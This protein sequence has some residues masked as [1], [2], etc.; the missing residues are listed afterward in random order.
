MLSS[1]HQNLKTYQDA[2]SEN[3]NSIGVRRV[4]ASLVDFDRW[5]D[6]PPRSAHEDQLKLHALLSRMS[7]YHMLPLISYNPWS[8][9][10]E[11]GK[12]LALVEDAVRNYGAVGVKIYPPNG[13]LPWAN[14]ATKIPK[15]PDGAEID[16][17]LQKFW[18]TCQDLQVPVL[19]HAGPSMGKD[20]LHSKLSG[21]AG[22]KSLLSAPWWPG[23]ERPRIVLGHFGGDS[24]DAGI[25]DWTLQFATLMKE[26]YGRNVYA[27]LGYWEKLR[28]PMVSPG[29]CEKAQARLAAVLSIDIG[30]GEVVADRVMY[31]SDWLMLSK[32]KNWPSYAQQLHASLR[33]FAPQFVERAFGTNAERCF[34]A[35]LKLSH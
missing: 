27:D 32:E 1:R 4:L 2:F 9:V 31:G 33:S 30:G 8:D 5:L 35:R 15:A 7:G 29:E 18:R 26:P 21:P 17:V 23:A 34:G 10:A 28:C 11:D 24:G 6:C 16:R 12:G 3:E 14:A 22:W 19:A 25:D 13:F 20:A